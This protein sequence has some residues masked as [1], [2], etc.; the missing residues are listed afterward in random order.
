MSQQKDFLKNKNLVV[1]RSCNELLRRLSRAEDAVFCGRVFIF[2]FQSFPL[3]DRSSVNLRGEFHVENVTTFEE[4]APREKSE[5]GSAMDVDGKEQAKTEGNVAEGTKTTTQENGVDGKASDETVLDT[6]ALYPV[7][8]RLQQAFSNPPR[9]FSSQPFQEFKSGLQATIT[10]FK[11]VPKLPQAR[12]AAESRRGTKRKGEDDA[13]DFASTFNPR[14]LTSK[15]LFRLEV[16][17]PIYCWHP[18]ADPCP[19][20]RSGFSKAHTRPGRRPRS[21]S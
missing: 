8:W 11:H 10:K 19:A 5:D 13:D 4:S 1:L 12:P 21:L 3:G 17:P 20:E 15:D 2:L 14:Y 7:F 6:D 18:D 16:V 9:L